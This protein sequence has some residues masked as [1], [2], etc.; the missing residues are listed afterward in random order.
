MSAATLRLED[1]QNEAQFSDAVNVYEGGIEHNPSMSKKTP[2]VAVY[3][4]CSTMKQFRN[5]AIDTQ[6]LSMEYLLRGMG[7]DIDE[8]SIYIDAGVSAKQY[9]RIESRPA[10]KQM[11][12]DVEAGLIKNI[13]VYSISR[14]FRNVAAGATWLEYMITKHQSIEIKSGDCPYDANDADGR[15]MWHLLMSFSMGENLQL[16]KKTQSGMDRLQEDLKKSSHAV[17]GWYYDEDLEK[18]QPDWHQ[19][20]VIRHVHTAWNDNKGQSFS[21]I[22]R[23]LKRWNIKT[24][25]GKDF[26]QGTVRRLVKKPARLHEQLHRFTEPKA[27]LK[28]PFRNYKPKA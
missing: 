26:N 3:L 2:H 28:A 7:Y 4:R 17:F 8:C 12:D 6:R 18:M 10:G 14:L 24:S 9:A 5:G 23:D 16:G 27:M 20:A 22:S 1:L 19:Q 21:A 11:M 15:T 25:T 13:Y